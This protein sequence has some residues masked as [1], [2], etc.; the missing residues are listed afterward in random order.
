MSSR[1]ADAA[2]RDFATDPARNVVL[3]ASAGTGKTT[4]LVERYLRLL[5]AGVAPA[6]VL[7]ITF[8]RQAAAEMRERIVGALRRGAAESAAERARWSALRDRLGEVAVSTVDAFCL[9]LLREFPLEADLDPG[10]G[11]ADETEIPGLIDE[12][13]DRAWTAASHLAGRDPGVA[14]LLARLGPQRT[15][16]ALRSLLAHRL[17]VPGALRRFLRGTPADLTGE[18]ACR[19][20]AAKLADRLSGL[21]REVETLTE[22]D[23]VDDVRAAIVARDLRRLP[24]MAEAD[25]PAIRAW[26]ERLG[27]T[28][29][30]RAGAPRRKFAWRTRAPGP[31]ARR[32]REAAAAVA[33][34]VGEALRAFERD[35]NVV[36]VRAVRRVF[37]VAAAEYRRALRSRALLDFPDLLER[38]VRLLRRMDEFAQSRFRLESR[39]HHVLVDEF[40]DTNRAQWELVSLLVQ[41]WGEGSGLVEEAPLRPTI[42]VVGDRKQSI[43]RFRGADVA[44][45][46]EA[47]QEI[48]GLRADGDVRRSI[49]RSFR[50]APPLLAFVNDL[51]AEISGG[52]DGRAAGGRDRFR[53]EADDAFPIERAPAPDP[54]EAPAALGVVAGQDVET[55]AEAVAAEI[56]RL[57][58]AGQVRPKG[59]SSPRAVRPED[60]AILFRTRE[61]HREFERALGRR[62]IRTHVHSGMGFFDAD[63]IKD[64]RALVRFLARPS[65]ELRAAALLRS[66]F[67]GVSDAGLLTL[68]GALSD[69]LAAPGP[70]A[71]AAALGEDDRR[72]LDLARRALAGWIGLVDRL[73]PA[74]VLDRALQEAAYAFEL[75]GPQA[76]QA[77]ANLRRLRGL[78]RRIQNRGYATLARVADQIDR[79]SSGMPNAAVEA[80]DAVALMTAHAAKGLEFPIVFLVDLGRGTQTHQPPV[81]VIPDRGDGRPSVTVWPHRDEADA[82]ERRREVEETKRLLYVAATRPRDRLY[83]SA[84]VEDGVPKFNPGSFG[85]VLPPQFASALAAAA[86]GPAGGSVAWRGRSGARH[87]FRVC[88]S[89]AEIGAGAGPAAAFDSVPAA[90]AGPAP[91]PPPATTLLAPLRARPAVERIAVTDASPEMLAA[92]GARA[93]AAP[94]ARRGQESG[95]PPLTGA[96]RGREDAAPERRTRQVGRLAHRLLRRYE[97]APVAPDALEQ[98]A[99]ELAPDVEAADPAAADEAPGGAAG[100]AADD[101]DV[102]GAAAPERTIGDE[103]AASAAQLYA[104]FAAQE[105]VAALAGRDALW[106]VPFSLRLPAA[107]SPAA[108]R[109]AVL[110]GAIDCLARDPDG[111]VTVLEFKTGAPHPDHRRQLDAYVAAARAMFPKAAVVG[112]LV[113]A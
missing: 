96:R 100:N 49:S 43:Y 70:P 4:V 59:G 78:V 31:A 98:A 63:E 28:F 34:H 86:G 67:A 45:F 82:E 68:A 16:S 5:R 36:A 72:I 83:L 38:A 30:T 99:R 22:A 37:A 11:V 2:A 40:Q 108:G 74:E 102:A 55:C 65:S 104:R 15:R 90:D 23:V 42:F 97:G 69:A 13:V 88:G 71:S 48:A 93:G 20:A 14:M 56:V 50:S 58:D 87:T 29:L 73:P 79:L 94:G 46:R 85:R 6:N 103:R 8:T 107:A 21:R 54:A 66:R 57:L 113:Y 76:E 19:N 17:V 39:Y 112:R 47:T 64:V 9:A 12:A 80:F 110:R 106:E 77:Q 75:R 89:A 26:F 61:S 44:T 53:F 105:E 91:E 18:R 60:V 95:A 92:L 7:A 111:R 51:F 52:E 33:P 10:F 3:E 84:V 62:S 24:E 41:S 81:R 25:A 35:V 32:R 1:P 109:P 27:E 101:V